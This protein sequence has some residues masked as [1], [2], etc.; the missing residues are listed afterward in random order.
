MY[1]KKRLFSFPG[2]Y[3]YNHK[4]HDWRYHNCKKKKGIIKKGIAKIMNIPYCSFFVRKNKTWR[5]KGS[6]FFKK[7]PK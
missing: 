3:F 7:N 6:D 5:K 4:S 1:L 2:G